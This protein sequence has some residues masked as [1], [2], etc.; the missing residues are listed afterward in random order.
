M[1]K[2][3]TINRITV[4]KNMRMQGM[5]RLISSLRHR[6][7]QVM[8]SIF[9]ILGVTDAAGQGIRF[10]MRWDVVF[11][12]F[13]S[14][15]TIFNRC[16]LNITEKCEASYKLAKP[17]LH[18]LN[19]FWQFSVSKQLTEHSLINWK[20]GILN[21]KFKSLTTHLSSFKMNYKLQK[22]LI[23]YLKLFKLHNCILQ[24]WTRISCWGKTKFFKA[25]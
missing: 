11:V 20:G 10:M 16:Y 8:T 17:V 2:S 24:T 19:M 22:K 6:L 13:I 18:N 1:Q 4:E 25:K 7:I 21:N 23:K 12:N 14:L 5:Y 9:T 15:H 3:P